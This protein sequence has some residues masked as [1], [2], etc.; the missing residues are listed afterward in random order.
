MKSKSTHPVGPLTDGPD[1]GLMPLPRHAID[2]L[3]VIHKVA[4]DV[5]TADEVRLFPAQHHGVAHTLQDTDAIGWSRG[6][7]DD[8]ELKLTT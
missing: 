1:V 7:C 5:S 2:D 6:G 8:R 4:G 3:T